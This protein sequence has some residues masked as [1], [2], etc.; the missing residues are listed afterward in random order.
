MSLIS[1]EGLGDQCFQY[2]SEEIIYREHEL[3]SWQQRESNSFN[4]ETQYT[5][6]NNGYETMVS[7]ESI[8]QRSYSI[9]REF[10]TPIGIHD[11][12]TSRSSTNLKT[13]EIKLHSTASLDTDHD[14]GPTT[15]NLRAE[16]NAYGWISQNIYFDEL[17]HDTYVRLSAN[18]EGYEYGSNLMRH[19]IGGTII[20]N[21]GSFGETTM[22]QQYDDL[23]AVFNFEKEVSIDLFIPA[24]STGLQLFFDISVTSYAGAYGP[25]SFVNMENTS[26]ISVDFHDDIEFSYSNPDFL[27]QPRS[28][29][30]HISVSEPK[31]TALFA[32]FSLAIILLGSF[33]KPSRKTIFIHKRDYKL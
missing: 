30:N 31:S 14:F 25:L 22:D 8:C 18:I 17:Y 16:S 24:Y 2:T 3:A 15:E 33:K 10:N 29:N 21:V 9:Q 32:L 11:Y 4:G 27:S 28:D 19:T 7:S 20:D 6:I 23:F 1:N 13:G 26:W 5:S 12:V